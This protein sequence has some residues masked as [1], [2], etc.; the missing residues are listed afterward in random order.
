MTLSIARWDVSGEL[1]VPMASSDARGLEL[2]KRG[3]FAADLIR[4]PPGGA[5]REHT[6]PGDHI[7]VVV[8]G[9]GW[10]EYD[11]EPHR[12]ERGHIYLVPGH[13]R[14]AIL[15]ETELTLVS[16]ADDHRDVGSP[17]RLDATREP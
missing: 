14:H 16:V 17:E 5:V 2:V 15:A 1:P 4:F 6:H 11:G 7:L 8:E 13:I 12:L 9:R 10:L 3:P